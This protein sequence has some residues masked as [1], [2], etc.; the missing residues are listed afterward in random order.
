MSTPQSHHREPNDQSLGRVLVVEPDSV[1]S[2]AI[3]GAL[4]GAGVECDP[5]STVEEAIGAAEGAA[6]RRSY[7]AALI[8]FKLDGDRGFDLARRLQRIDG[9]VRVVMTGSR[10]TA[11]QTVE[12]MRAGAVDV[13]R[14]PIDAGEARLCVA[15]AIEAARRLRQQERK[16]VRLKKICRRLNE[17]RKSVHGQVDHLCD[18]LVGT[19]QDMADQVKKVSEVSEFQALVKQ[20]LD[21]EQLLRT[22]LEHTLQKTGPTNAAVFLPSNHAD[23]SLGAYVNYDCPKDAADVLLDHLADVIPPRFQDEEGVFTFASMDELREWIGDD[24]AWL[25]DSTALVATCRRD[26]ECLA[27]I[28]LFRDRSRPFEG[29]AVEQLASISEVFAGQLAKVI[30]VHHRHTPGSQWSGWETEDDDGSGGMAA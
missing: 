24:A 1:S 12:A 4:R 26:G 28:T 3:A 23:F 13:L 2:A 7:D 21:I 20:E 15:S 10:V 16:I 9:A 25:A 18:D 19:Y 11:E 8:S 14:L 6:G 30:S 17:S 29:D 5:V 22:T 27:V